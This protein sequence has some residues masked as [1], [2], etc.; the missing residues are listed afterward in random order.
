MPGSNGAMSHEPSVIILGAGAA[1]LSAA[2]ELSRAGL[3]V[4]ILEARDR[5]GGR[6]FTKRDPVCGAPVE[7]GA[8]FI[9]GKSPEIW[10]LLRKHKAAVKEVQGDYLCY[11]ERKL[12]PCD[13]FSQVDTLLE[14]MDDEGPDISFDEFLERCC[15]EAKS[16]RKQHEAKLWAR[17]YVT[18]FHAADPKLI[19]IHSLVKGQRAEQQ[20]DGKRAFRIAKGY[21]WLVEVFERQVRASGIAIEL[22]TVAETIQWSRGKVEVAARNLAGPLVFTAP[23]VLLTLPLGVL[24]AADGES[25][26]VRFIPQLPKAKQLALGRFVMGRVHRVVLRFRERFWDD[27]RPADNSKA[28][29][30]SNMSFLF[31]REKWFPTWWTTMPDKMPIITGWA[32]AD[33][34]DQLSGHDEAH[35]VD[36]AL[37]VLGGILDKSRQA[38]GVA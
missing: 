19:S 27:I 6:M 1:G 3:K 16:D 35:V 25:G 36:K 11:H 26:V 7:L 34:A 13:F 28:R 10:D 2:L 38:E 30:L 8:E 29:T 4:L 15:P 9:H 14:K 20:I 18:G 32:P 33:Y 12:R 21:G 37:G 5:L 22:N 17:G 23:R 31:S 24:Q